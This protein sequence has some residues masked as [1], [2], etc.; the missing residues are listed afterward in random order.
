MKNYLIWVIAILVSGCVNSH[1]SKQVSKTAH[2][3]LEYKVARL[4]KPLVIDANWDKPAW[5]KITPLTLGNHMGEPPA[6]RPKVLSKI[7]W[8]EQ[9][10]YIIFR[11]EDRYVRAVAKKHQGYVYKD[12]CVEL[13]FT[14]GSKPSGSYFNVEINCGGTM[15]FWWHPENGPAIPVAAEDA[16]QIKIAHSMPKIVDPEITTPT[17]WTLEYRLP[18]SVIRKYFPGATQPESGGSWKANLYKCADDTSHPHWL[19]WSFV[20]HPTPKF[21]VPQSFGTLRFE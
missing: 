10:L 19:T 20:D 7:A 4:S 9:A 15:L 17:T 14:P 3:P 11:V 5:K 16:R 8:N 6:H 12:S 21:H 1:G 2:Q 13:F 18:F